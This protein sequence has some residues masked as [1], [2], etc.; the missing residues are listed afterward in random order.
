MCIFEQQ[1]ACVCR[2]VR[3]TEVDVCARLCVYVSLAEWAVDCTILSSMVADHLESKQSDAR[4]KHEA[5]P[6]SHKA[7]PSHRTTGSLEMI[8]KQCER[9]QSCSSSA[10]TPASTELMLRHGSSMGSSEAPSRAI[11]SR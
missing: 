4:S 1:D 8:Q 11:F 5:E 9:D 10:I 2:S 6:S 3:V 7:V